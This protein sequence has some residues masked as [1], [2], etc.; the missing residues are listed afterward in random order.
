MRGSLLS[1]RR[2]RLR[3]PPPVSEYASKHGELRGFKWLAFTSRN[4]T[5]PTETLVMAPSSARTSARFPVEMAI[6]LLASTVTFC[7]A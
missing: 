1:I 4:E 2:S 6:P 3:S 7:L 5:P